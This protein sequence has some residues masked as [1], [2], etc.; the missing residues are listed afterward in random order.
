MHNPDYDN[1]GNKLVGSWLSAMDLAY[2][3]RGITIKAPNG[4]EI[5]YHNFYVLIQLG[6]HSL[7][8]SCMWKRAKMPETSAKTCWNHSGKGW[9]KWAGTP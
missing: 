1:V 4:F 6:P 2:T 8:T 3:W 9:K 7:W 5:S